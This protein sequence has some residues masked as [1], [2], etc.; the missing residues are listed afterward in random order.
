MAITQDQITNLADRMRIQEGLFQ[1]AV[2][3]LSNYQDSSTPA[4]KQIA[5]QL[6]RVTIDAMK[7]A[8]AGPIAALPAEYTEPQVETLATGL[9]TLRNVS[10]RFMEGLAK[11]QRPMLADEDGNTVRDYTQAQK[12]ALETELRRLYTKMTTLLNAAPM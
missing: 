12:D 8:V 9:S 11:A 6:I 2:Q 10:L 3:S 4:G 1:L 7:Q 5:S